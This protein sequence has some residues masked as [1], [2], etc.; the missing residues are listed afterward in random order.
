MTEHLL[1][2]GASWIMERRGG[3]TE[4]LTRLSMLSINS[5]CELADLPVDEACGIETSHS[6]SV[7]V[8]VGVFYWMVWS[9][10][11]LTS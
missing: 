5:E 9:C 4:M 11:V 2:E 10:A 3:R 8:R 6:V 1:L 7:S